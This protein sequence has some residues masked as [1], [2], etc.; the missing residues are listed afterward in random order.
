MR[1]M[2]TPIFSD[3]KC[4]QLF[5]RWSSTSLLSIKPFQ[6]SFLTQRHRRGGRKHALL[7]FTS[8]LCSPRGFLYCPFNWSGLLAPST[9]L[10]GGQTH[11][12]SIHRKKAS[13]IAS[14]FSSFSLTGCE[15]WAGTRHI[16]LAHRRRLWARLRAR[17]TSH[18][19]LLYWWLHVRVVRSQEDALFPEWFS[20]CCELPLNTSR[21]GAPLPFCTSFS[22]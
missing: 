1:G 8:A 12:L 4:D 16:Q 13:R 17:M 10:S 11:S 9:P 5:P 15:G 2:L 19:W 21:D 18:G 7:R 20:V 3:R 14:E 6:L 22:L